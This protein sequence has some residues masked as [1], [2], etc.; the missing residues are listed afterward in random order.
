M[1]LGEGSLSSE[2][3]VKLRDSLSSLL[4]PLVILIELLD[5]GGERDRVHTLE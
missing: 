1:V 3:L 2:T 5:T 4:A